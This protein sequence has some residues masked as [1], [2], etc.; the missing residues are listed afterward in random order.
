MMKNIALSESSMIFVSQAQLYKQRNNTA[1]VIC[2]V[3]YVEDSFL[4]N[5]PLLFVFHL[6]D[7][8]TP[9]PDFIIQLTYLL[10]QMISS[11]L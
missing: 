10:K 5:L 2:H 9:Q 4:D 8:K 11:V 7:F 3:C 6:V 1:S